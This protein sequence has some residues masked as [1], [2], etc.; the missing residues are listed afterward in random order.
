MG[1]FPFGARGAR[2][3]R[4]AGEEV[5]H[6]HARARTQHLRMEDLIVLG[7]SLKIRHVTLTTARVLSSFVRFHLEQCVYLGVRDRARTG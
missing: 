1:D 4:L 6:D 3:V 5:V 7:T 2:A